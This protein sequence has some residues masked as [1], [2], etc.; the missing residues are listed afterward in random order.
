[1]LQLK[2]IMELHPTHDVTEGH[3][4]DLKPL[5]LYGLGEE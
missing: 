5:G 4:E 2:L 1:M 3:I